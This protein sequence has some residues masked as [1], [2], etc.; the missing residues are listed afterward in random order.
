MGEWLEVANGDQLLGNAVRCFLA[1]EAGQG[2]CR[3]TGFRL[4]NGSLPLRSHYPGSGT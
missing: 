2:I 1:A 4:P 3:L